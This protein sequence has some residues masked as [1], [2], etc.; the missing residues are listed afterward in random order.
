VEIGKL[1]LKAKVVKL[2]VPGVSLS[3]GDG[4]ND[5]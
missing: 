4:K 2:T 1:S 5:E 3:D